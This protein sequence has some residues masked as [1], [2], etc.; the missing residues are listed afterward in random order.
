MSGVTG[1]LQH[2]SNMST[3]SLNLSSAIIN[4]FLT[5]LLVMWNYCIEMVEIK[6]HI[7]FN[8][9]VSTYVHL[10]VNILKTTPKVII[11]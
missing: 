6:R 7:I 9:A 2:S 10:D 1:P 11:D 3:A 5:N 4:K 8:Q